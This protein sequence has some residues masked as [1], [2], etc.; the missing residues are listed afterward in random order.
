LALAKNMAEGRGYLDGQ[1]LIALV[2]E[3]DAQIGLT[4]QYGFG[5]GTIPFEIS[6]HVHRTPPI[7]SNQVL[8]R[9]GIKTVT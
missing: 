7:A 3:F 2:G 8:C 1:L 4:R 6:G 9:L 5:Q